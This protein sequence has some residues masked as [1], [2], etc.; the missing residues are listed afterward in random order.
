MKLLWPN[1][2]I[3]K[4]S[5]QVCVTCNQTFALKNWCKKLIEEEQLNS[6][7]NIVTKFSAIEQK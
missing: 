1:F 5:T 7:E 3:K 4:G 2:Q 6:G